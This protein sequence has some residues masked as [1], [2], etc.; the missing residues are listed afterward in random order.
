MLRIRSSRPWFEVESKEPLSVT[1]D[2]KKNYSFAIEPLDDQVLLT[3][4]TAGKAIL[5][6]S[7]TMTQHLI[8]HGQLR[9]PLLGILLIDPTRRQRSL[10]NRRTF[11]LQP[12]NCAWT[13]PSSVQTCHTIFATGSR[14]ESGSV[15]RIFSRNSTRRSSPSS[16]GS[17]HM[18]WMEGWPATRSAA[19]LLPAKSF[20][21][22]ELH[23][24][25]VYSRHWR[26]TFHS[27]VVS[28]L[29][30]LV[31]LSASKISPIH[32]GSGSVRPWN[33]YLTVGLV[34]GRHRCRPHQTTTHVDLALDSGC[35][36]FPFPYKLWGFVSPCLFCS[37]CRAMG[38]VGTGH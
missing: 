25:Y 27:F 33:C 11:P 21:M 10:P 26:R 32:T 3:G 19:T 36:T 38:Y 34:R 16:A 24:A 15:V 37:L 1:F 22:R 8:D 20:H 18:Y 2:P 30:G 9:V 29:V 5:L 6:S 4:S 7:S 12:F 17:A 23:Q 13:Y 28:T 35:D 14:G 31:S